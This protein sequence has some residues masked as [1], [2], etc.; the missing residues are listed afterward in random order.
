[1]GGLSGRY[2]LNSHS[3]TCALKVTGRKVEGFVHP[4]VRSPFLLP[5][6]SVACSSGDES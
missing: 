5:N 4:V 2:R 3:H 1:M 6:N